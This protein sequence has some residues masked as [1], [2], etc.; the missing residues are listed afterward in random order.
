LLASPSVAHTVV[1][2]H[3]TLNERVRAGL[4]QV[5]YAAFD[6]VRLVDL[7]F[8]QGRALREADELWAG[9]GIVVAGFELGEGAPGPPVYGAPEVYARL[10]GS[11]RPDYGP[12][13]Q[14][15]QELAAQR[16]LLAMLE[17]SLSWRVT[18]PLRALSRLA[19]RSSSR[20]Q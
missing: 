6:K 16:Q 11:M 7:D 17:R 5:N 18:A 1:L 13:A 12:L 10:A 15:E 19:R 14:V 8:V 4:E 20:R 2:I 9:L 3:D